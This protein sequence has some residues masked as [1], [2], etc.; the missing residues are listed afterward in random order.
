MKMEET[1]RATDK[2][3]LDNNERYSD[4]M[5]DA[6]YMS[7]GDSKCRFV[8]G[9]N[10]IT[11][12]IDLGA[13]FIINHDIPYR[14][15]NKVDYEYNGY[16]GGNDAILNFILLQVPKSPYDDTEGNIAYNKFG[17]YV[18]ELF[19]GKDIC[20]IGEEN[21]YIFRTKQLISYE[22]KSDT[23][24]ITISVENNICTLHCEYDL[25]LIGKT[26]NIIVNNDEGEFLT[27]KK[28]LIKG[29]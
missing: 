3:L 13:R 21:E 10:S 12:K 7:Y 11:E 1:P 28:V 23:D 20:Y 2:K 22:L 19:V 24:K 25:S 16:T 4:G 9:K 27:N 17:K 14:V 29:V 5:N 15:T 26:V 18:D 8:I 6:R